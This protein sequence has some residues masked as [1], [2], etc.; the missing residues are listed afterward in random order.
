MG[1]KHPPEGVE[2]GDFHSH[3]YLFEYGCTAVRAGRSTTY[4]CYIG[5]YTDVVEKQ[6]GLK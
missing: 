2:K 1:E 5:G 3:F 6:W 4:G